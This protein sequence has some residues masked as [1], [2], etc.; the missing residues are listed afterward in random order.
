MQ[1]LRL[2]ITVTALL[3]IFLFQNNG[4]VF[5]QILNLNLSDLSNGSAILAKKKDSGKTENNKQDVII[6][7][8]T[9][10]STPAPS[11]TST[12]PTAS[13]TPTTP[14]TPSPTPTL[15]PTVAVT[16]TKTAT[17]S[18]GIKKGPT[19][20]AVPTVF[21][22]KDGAVPVTYGLIILM[23]ALGIV[24]FANHSTKINQA[25]HTFFGDLKRKRK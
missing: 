24:F 13:P 2:F 19:P 17:A 21:Q 25:L 5:G 1:K 9:P 23:A 7:Q 20:T 3:A 10:S 15:R 12:Q 6:A 18:A 8:S 11:P 14:L 16:P 22:Y 4:L